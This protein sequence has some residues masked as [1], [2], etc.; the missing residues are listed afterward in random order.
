MSRSLTCTS[1][2]RPPPGYASCRRGS[3]RE[4]AGRTAG[5]A[6]SRS[7]RLTGGWHKRGGW[8]VL[9]RTGSGGTS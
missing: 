1:H 7:I 4:L 2:L 6:L 5:P 9:A 8:R 3:S